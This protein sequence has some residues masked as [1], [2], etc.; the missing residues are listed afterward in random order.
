MKCNVCEK[1]IEPELMAR[2][3]ISSSH[4]EEYRSIGMRVCETC[5]ER[6]LR[7]C[8]HD[9]LAAVAH[10]LALGSFLDTVAD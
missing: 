2:M 6:I 10:S 3:S 4:G 5:R 9:D 7:D 8:K 1:D